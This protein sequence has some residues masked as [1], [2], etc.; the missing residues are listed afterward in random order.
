MQVIKQLTDFLSQG[1]EDRCERVDL[2]RI[3]AI[4]FFSLVSLLYLSI[5]GTISLVTLNY[6]G[7]A[8]TLVAALLVISN[9]F[10]L[11]QKLQ[12]K[13]SAA[14]LITI[15]A[16]V[17]IFQL[18]SGTGDLFAYFIF[19]IFPLVALYAAGP[20]FGTIAMLILLIINS[21]VLFIPSF[22]T[23]TAKNSLIFNLFLLSIHLL[24]FIIAYFHQHLWM[25][26]YFS[27]E[28]RMQEDRA[29]LRTR[30][31]F[32][33][34]LSH[35]LRTPLNNISV[36]N[37]LLSATKLDEKQKDL[38]DTI[39]ASTNNLANVVNSIAKVSNV[40]VADI[41]ETHISFNLQST[42]QNT[43]KLFAEQGSRY[44]DIN[45]KVS[46]AL[47]NNLYG[48]PIKL[49]QIFLNLIENILKNQSLEKIKIYIQVN[50]LKETNSAVDLL[51]KI[52][53]NNPI[54][55]IQESYENYLF[56][57][58][59]DQTEDKVNSDG[60]SFIDL[61]IARRI[62]EG[63]G[64]KLGIHTDSEQTE[65]DF[66]I[67]YKKDLSR[68]TSGEAREEFQTIAKTFVESPRVELKDSN[69][70]L[71]EDNLINQKIVVLS[72]QKIVRNIDIANNGKEALDKFG[73]T[74]YDLILMDIQ[75]P[76]MDGI[77]ATKKIRE[78]EASSNTHT[79]IIAI[80]ANALSGDK[81][82]CLAAGMNDYIS[83]PFQ[84]DVLIQKMRNLLT[85]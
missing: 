26:N 10:Y 57:A 71:V 79:P 42:L 11:Y 38:L 67:S 31:E 22:F 65:F 24:I 56:A 52:S 53:T 8:I 54:P 17:Q 73:T 39:I 61:T 28:R 20:R 80:T 68:I 1:F 9:Y 74:K 14:T 70:L 4:N 44:L 49:K 6:P 62:I 35:Q 5:T 69:V 36:I 51:V 16:V 46:N 75:M 84:V 7:A 27:L 59:M 77:V 13:T 37:N 33:S 19:L 34:K 32:I 29:E 47:T 45:L 12:Y 78:I 43:I 50:L 25:K 85:N 30:D 76:V 48:D 83:K 55:N 18:I 40:E 41:K 72:L 15:L 23:A 2:N 81:E 63:Y 60:L 82:I 66:T 3:I 58:N 21:V 64:G